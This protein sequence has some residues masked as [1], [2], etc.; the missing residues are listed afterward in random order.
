MQTNKGEEVQVNVVGSSTFGRYPKISLEK[1]YNMFIS[2]NWLINYPGF[3]KKLEDIVPNGEGRGIFNSIRGGFLLAVIDSSVYQIGNNFTPLLVGSIAT[4]TGDVYIDENL[5]SQICIVD[6]ENAY[7]YDY[8]SPSPAVTPQTLTYI[9]NQIFPNYVCYHN[10]FFLFGNSPRS[11]NSSNWYAYEPDHGDPDALP[12]VPAD[13]TKIV[14]NTQF[15]LQTKPDVALVVTRLPGKGNNVLVL[16]STVAEVWTQVGGLENYRRIQSFNIDNGIVST[17]TVSASEEIVCWLAQNENLDVSIMVTDGSS[18]KRISTDG[19]DYVLSNIKF[20]AQSTAFFHREG[21]HLFYQITFYN[22]AD[23]LSLVYDFDEGKFFHVSDQNLNYHPAREIV[24]FL[25]EIYF[26]SLDDGSIYEMSTDFVT[27]NYDIL[28]HSTGEEIPRIRICKT[29]RKNN[30][31]RFRVGKF[32][33]WIEQGVNDYSR[34]NPIIPRVDM[35]FSKDGNQSFSSIISKPLNEVGKRRNQI[36]E[37]RMGQANE[38][39]IQLSFLG[40]QSFVCTGGTAEIY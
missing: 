16:G 2:E 38:F 40:M 39:T 30:S 31:D 15:S 25:G 12:P 32:T 4:K 21:G 18:T 8:M 6:G 10:S 26:I 28:P 13:P 19:I 37:W 29:L 14:R 33:F 17:P 35:S 34:P 22:A 5:A 23:N 20:P 9:G 3:K 1:T 7:I 36:T 27:Y 24:F 11:I